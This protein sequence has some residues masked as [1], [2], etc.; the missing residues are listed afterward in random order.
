MGALGDSGGTGS[1]DD[2]LVAAVRT[3][4]ADA[5]RMVLEAGADPDAFGADG[6]P[7][8]CTAVAAYDGPVAEALVDGGA[9]QNRLLPD[10]TTPLLR[11]VELGSPAV[12]TALL[13]NEPQLRLPQT[14]QKRLLALARNWYERGAAEELRRRTGAPGP[15]EVLVIPDC[16]YNRVEQISVGGL[17]VRAGHGA[18]LTW[19]EEAF[20]IPTPVGE[21]AARALRHP[22]EEDANWHVDWFAACFTLSQRRDKDTWSAVEAMRHHP[23]PAHRA[24]VACSLGIGVGIEPTDQDW[25]AKE[26]NRLL[27]AWAAEEGDG[28]VLAKVLDAHPGGDHPDKEALGLRYTNHTDPRVRREVP[29]FLYARGTPPTPEATTALLALAHDPDPAVR[30]AVGNALGAG[31]GL[32]PDIRNALLTL[33]RDPDEGA[34]S[35]AAVALSRFRDRTPAVTDAFRALLDEENQLLRLEGAYGLAQLDD[36]RTEEAYERVGPLGPAFDIDHRASGLWQWRSRN[37][38]ERS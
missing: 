38:P 33:I 37:R 10:G 17:T 2:R 3:R 26:R 27:T 34:R 21:L 31:P 32:T 18:V 24:F 29:Y 12:V 19:L 9:H 36:P 16:E 7:V 23:S 20:H 15:A 4:D 35:S 25:Y 11:A 6:L 30:R 28:K 13:G 1:Q 14:A 5:V 8:L 22:E